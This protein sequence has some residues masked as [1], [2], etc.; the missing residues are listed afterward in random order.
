L[1]RITNIF[2]NLYLPLRTRILVI[3]LLPVLLYPIIIIY[4]NKYQDI[5]IR[6]EFA[7]IERQ[8]L[9]LTKALA[10]AENQYGLIQRNQVSSP[11]LQSLIP[12]VKYS[13]NIRARLFDM[14]G[15]LIA[16]TKASM[17]YTPFVKIS[18]LPFV[19]K[20]SSFEKYFTSFV[21]LFTNLISRPLNLPLYKEDIKFKI[22]DFPEVINALKGINN[23]VLR[24]DKTGKLFLSVA[25]PI[26]NI[27]MVRGAVLLSVSGEK[28][29]QE[30]IDLETELFR[31]FGL[32]LLA[33]LSL[34]FYFGKSITNP[35]IKLA[36][37]ADKIS[38]DKMLKSFNLTE[39]KSRK[40][41]IG[42]LAKSFFEM[43]KELQSRIDHIAEFA[44]DVAHE[45]KNP[46]SSM[47]SASET[48]GKI[49]NV[50]E[51]KQLIK[52]IQNDVERV[53]RLIND[54]S[55]ASRLDAELSRI[56]MTKINITDLL[57]TLIDIRSSTI[58]CNINFF[59][60]VETSYILGNENRIAQVFDNLIQNS[61]SFSNHNC[62]I[63]IRLEKNL[64]KIIILV[65][66][67]GPGFSEIGMHKVFDRFYTERP[68]TEKFGNHSGLGLS[69]SKQILEA[70]GGTIEAFN[71]LNKKNK[72]VGATVKTSFNELKL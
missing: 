60:E 53:D 52:V 49:K 65:E 24:Q 64:E 3:I 5:L 38:E 9:T 7:A 57:T 42:N 47:R 63:D 71:R 16:D 54:I 33:T 68:K 51:Q 61:A 8:G 14:Y 29:E 58:N 30:L 37:E 17:K 12:K 6:S 48:I 23:K 27:R 41:E 18:P 19:N 40:D 66:D 43:T 26:K 59:K 67:N 55:A 50:K 36:K 1:Y 25:I 56:E 20:S 2:K 44:A 69:I 10:L 32:I 70:H 28:I 34:A 72:C 21:S 35:I 13:S 4:F 15:N 62:R 45:L 39:L 46:I 31:A 22:N 11:A